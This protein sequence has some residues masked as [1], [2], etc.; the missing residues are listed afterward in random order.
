MAQKIRDALNSPTENAVDFL[1]N[2]KLSLYT[3]EIVVFTPKGEPRRLPFGA[4]A[5]D[6]AYD[7]HTNVGNKAIGAKI[8]HKLEPVTTQISSGDQIEIITADNAVPKPNG[9]TW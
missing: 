5:L 1:D 2:F 4:T 8:N 3:S 6:F 9:S 7:I